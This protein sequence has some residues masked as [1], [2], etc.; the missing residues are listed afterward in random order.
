MKKIITAL[1]LV[2]AAVL[3]AACSTGGNGATTE[4]EDYS[5]LVIN[6]SKTVRYSELGMSAYTL[7]SSNRRVADAIVVKNETL[8]IVVRAYNPGT[9]VITVTDW[10]GRTG[11]V[12][13]TVNEKALIAETKVT[14]KPD[15]GIID[16]KAFGARGNGSGG[17]AEI[18]QNAINE[19]GRKGGGT[20]YIPAGVYHINS[21]VILCENIDIELQGRVGKAT[22]GYTDELK[23]RI[24]DGE[25]AVLTA[26]AF[27][28][29]DPA[30]PGTNAFGNIVIRGGVMDMQGYLSDG[31]QIDVDQ[32]GPAV[33]STKSCVMI[34]ANA[35]GLTFEDV[36]VKDIYNGHAFQLTGAEDMAIRNCLFAGYTIRSETKGS[37]NDI[38]TTRETIQ[39]EYAHSGAIPPTFYE[40]GEYYFCRNVEITDCCFTK[41]DKAGY[42]E[43]PIGQH[44][45]N[46]RPNC[47]GVKITGNVFDNP[48]IAGIRLLC[49]HDVEITGNT[50]VSSLSSTGFN[51][52]NCSMII[53]P[54]ISSDK[55]YNGKLKNGKTATIR[56]CNGWEQDG[57]KNVTISGNTFEICK[58]SLFR[59]L[60]A[61]SNILETGARSVENQIRQVEGQL[62]GDRFT[63]YLPVSNVIDGL[64]FT[65]N[66][67][68]FGGK[69]A[70][71][72]NWIQVNYT[73][74]FVYSDNNVSGY[75]G[76]S[77]SSDGINGLLTL[78]NISGNDAKTRVITA[79]VS[80]K[81]IT[82]EGLNGKKHVYISDGAERKITLNAD[83]GVKE[84]EMSF[85]GGNVTVR[86]T[87]Y[88]G[89]V[90]S[91]WSNGSEMLDSASNE[92]LKGD[93]TLTAVT[94]KK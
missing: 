44:G 6:D 21:N 53:A 39:I 31:A 3:F 34:F 46:G 62:V 13:V 48:Y 43:I 75:S 82:L 55:S 90:F 41:S 32:A 10:W 38:V 51:K 12:E 30:G 81:K 92:T 28:N 45:M 33:G 17:D 66:T 86:V 77:D 7:K 87:C 2:L 4:T 50:F 78:G 91:G 8:G 94:T 61:S 67:V 72:A 5:D 1:V 26:P 18:L 89:Y 57:T 19:L 93:L 14:S 24:G 73:R 60:V 79:S 80:D 35:R 59:V 68:K 71:T 23:S 9:A 37:K 65:G 40:E 58:G 16:L 54:L 15:D 27:I 49:Y 69:P 74:N 29:H 20:L 25:F 63:G 11:T 85:S 76:F 88:E 47:T 70:N 52:K 64:Y 56:Y 84:L 42:H 83:D 22:D 36:V